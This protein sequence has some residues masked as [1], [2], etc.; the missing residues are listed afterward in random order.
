[1]NVGNIGSEMDDFKVAFD[2]VGQIT[3]I[4]CGL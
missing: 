1:M 3:N 4:F 2:E